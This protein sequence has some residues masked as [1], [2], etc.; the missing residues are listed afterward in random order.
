LLG[1]VTDKLQINLRLSREELLTYIYFIISVKR[2]TD[3]NNG[4]GRPQAR[5]RGVIW[6]PGRLKHSS[7]TAS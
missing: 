3:Q 1:Y 4:H 2:R 7:V 6:H 5:A